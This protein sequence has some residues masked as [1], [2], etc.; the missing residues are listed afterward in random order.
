[1]EQDTQASQGIQDYAKDR[2]LTS[3]FDRLGRVFPIE[4][5][6]DL[7]SKLTPEMKQVKVPAYQ[8]YG[9]YVGTAENEKQRQQRQV[10]PGS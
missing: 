3:A 9:L 6:R 5:L 10:F 7:K 4:R 1:M 8:R 2:D